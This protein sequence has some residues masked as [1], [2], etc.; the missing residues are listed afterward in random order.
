[1]D[2]QQ[3]IKVQRAESFEW[4]RLR[5]LDTKIVDGTLSPSEVQAV[6]AHLR[7]NHTDIVQLLSDIQLAKLVSSTPVSNL[8]TAKQELGKDLPDELLYEKGVESDVFT[9][10]LSGKVTAVVG[11][12]SFRTDLSPWSVLGRAAFDNPTFVPDFSAFVSD[13]PCR[14]LQFKHAKFVEAVD[15]TAIERR[16]S[17]MKVTAS[18]PP[19]PIDVTDVSSA[20][21]SE[22]PNRR[23][24]LIARLFKKDSGS[25]EPDVE[26]P[27]PEKTTI[28]RFKEGGVLASSERQQI[29]ESEREHVKKVASETLGSNDEP[30]VPSTISSDAKAETPS[31]ESGTTEEEQSTPSLELSSEHQAAGEPNEELEAKTLSGDIATEHKAGPK[32]PPPA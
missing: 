15:A 25:D 3:Q 27:K 26:S 30:S 29:T 28:V 16:V 10:I 1:M 8:E 20:G 12:E 31:T 24:K 6:T 18:T 23:E 14:C 22:A 32:P 11:A 5:L 9:L 7:M 2:G 19:I 17:E 13:G 21:S 4:A